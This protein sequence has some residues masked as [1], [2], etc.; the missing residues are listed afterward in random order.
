MIVSL[1]DGSSGCVANLS[2]DEGSPHQLLLVTQ[3]RSRI[4][5]PAFDTLL[6]S[7]VPYEFKVII[8]ERERTIAG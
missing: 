1:R 7:S 3:P 2:E 8:E 5:P 6:L 4:V